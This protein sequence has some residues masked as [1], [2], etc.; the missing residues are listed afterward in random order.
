MK[1]IQWKDKSGL[2]VQRET[3]NKKKTRMGRTIYRR[4]YNWKSGERYSKNESETGRQPEEEEQKRSIDT[5]RKGKE[6]QYTDDR[7]GVFQ[8][9]EHIKEKK[10]KR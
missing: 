8:K 3:I 4:C 7:K 9:R 2:S 1:R 5:E 6:K 10:V